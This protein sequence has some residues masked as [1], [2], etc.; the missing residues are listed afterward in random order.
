MEDA[1]GLLAPFAYDLNGMK[2]LYNYH[3]PNH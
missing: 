2:Y 1:P 3:E